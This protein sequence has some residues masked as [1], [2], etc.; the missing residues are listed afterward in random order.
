VGSVAS[1]AAVVALGYGMYGDDVPLRFLFIVIGALGLFLGI[2]MLSPLVVR[3]LAGIL[4]TPLASTGMPGVLARENSRRNPQRTASTAAALMI[5]IAVVAA[6]STLGS[7]IDKSLHVVLDRSVKAQVIVNYDQGTIDPAVEDRVRQDPDVVDAVPIRYNTFRLGGKKRTLA[8]MP[9][10]TLSHV[11]DLELKQGSL[12]AFAGGGVLLHEDVA[13]SLG[14]RAGDT[15]RMGF[16]SGPRDEV[17]RGVFANNQVTNAS[18]MIPVAEYEQVYTEQQDAVVFVTTRPGVAP[19]VVARRLAVALKTDYPQLEVLDQKAFADQQ[20]SQIRSILLVVSALLLLSIII[21]LLGIA[22]TLALSVFERT[23]EIGLLRAVGTS[24]RQTRRMIR[25]ESII[26]AVLG[27]GL[28]VAIGLAFGAAAVGALRDEGLTQ[29][30]FPVRT[31]VLV[32][33]MSIFA[34]VLAAIFPARRAARLDVLQ[35]IASE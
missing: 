30:A 21:A 15:L 19:A 25:Y 32:L 20:A 33:V 22:N 13:R 24:R 23:R 29:L 17:V 10:A 16:P 34:G 18:Y 27:S 3:P 35:A 1:L 2:A 5:G 7:S 28:G 14:K 11:F 8:A 6:V 12:A 4:G 26:I 31:M 9:A